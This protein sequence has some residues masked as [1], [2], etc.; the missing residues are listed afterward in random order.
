MS[1]NLSVR[2]GTFVLL[3]QTVVTDADTKWEGVAQ[4]DL[5]DKRV[6]VEGRWKG[7]RKL[8]AKNVISRGSGRDRIAGRIDE[9]KMVE[10]GWEARV[11]IFT[12]LMKTDTIC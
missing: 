10:G 4:S 8:V 6:K 12:M 11:M 1:L 3:G 7:P 5:A 9:L 2:R